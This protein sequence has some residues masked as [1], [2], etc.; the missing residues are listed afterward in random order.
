MFKWNLIH[1]SQNHR[2][3]Q[4]E[5]G[6]ISVCDQSGDTPDKTDDGPLIV[7]SG[8][9]VEVV[10]VRNKVFVCV[11]VK[12]LRSNDDKYCYLVPH[13][14]LALENELTVYINYSDEYFALKQIVQNI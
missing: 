10:L 9:E 13:D 6:D 12:Q 8:A 14:F 7:Q 4:N 5:Y 11:P 2:L 1:D 3:F